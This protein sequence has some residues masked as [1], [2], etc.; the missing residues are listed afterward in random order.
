MLIR[1]LVQNYSNCRYDQSFLE[2]VEYVI[3]S[4][5][6]HPPSTY[7]LCLSNFCNSVLNPPISEHHSYQQLQNKN[8]ILATLPRISVHIH[9]CPSSLRLSSPSYLTRKT[10]FPP[11]THTHTHTYT[12]M[13]FA[14]SKRSTMAV[15][16]SRRQAGGRIKKRRS[17]PNGHLQNYGKICTGDTTGMKKTPHRIGAR[18]SFSQQS[19]GF[20][21]T[22]RSTDSSGSEKSRKNPRGNGAH[23][24]G[25]EGDFL[26]S[27]QHSNTSE[28]LAHAIVRGFRARAPKKLLEF[29]ERR[30]SPSNATAETMVG[31]KEVLTC[32]P[33]SLYAV[34]A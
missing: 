27:P 2:Y 9:S 10:F 29:L 11:Y 19:S 3:L 24:T 6:L 31:I 33:S 26:A 13:P 25:R 5:L 16:P 30:A 21:G 14:G 23:I 32:P 1:F 22:G 28:S 15:V 12:L 18:Q 17:G 8:I 7:I 4:L 20:G 34:V